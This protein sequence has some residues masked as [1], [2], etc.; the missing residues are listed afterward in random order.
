MDLQLQP[1]ELPPLLYH[2]T[3]AHKMDAI[4]R[5]GLRKMRRN[6]APLT[7]H[8]DVASELATDPRR[9]LQAMRRANNLFYRSDNIVWLVTEVPSI[10]LTP[11]SRC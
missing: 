2:G 11:V 4:M 8:A 6:R 9:Y 5:E 10:F 1:T 7:S 3:A